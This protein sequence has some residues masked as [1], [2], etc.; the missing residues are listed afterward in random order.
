MVV[1]ALGLKVKGQDGGGLVSQL[2]Q[3]PV[4]PVSPRA[5]G[6]GALCLDLSYRLEAGIVLPPVG[7]PTG[8]PEVAMQMY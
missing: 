4:R 8:V 2:P 7:D 3:T 6:A 1:L 5:E